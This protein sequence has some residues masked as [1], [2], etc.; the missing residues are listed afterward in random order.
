MMNPDMDTAYSPQW[1]VTLEHDIAGKGVIGSISYVGANGIKLYSLN[2]LNQRGSCLLAPDINPTCVPDGSRTSRLNQTGLTGMNRRGN[3][4]L[5][6]YNGMILSLR[7]PRLGNTGLSLS[8]SYGWSH[9]IDNE[10]SFFADSPFEANYGFGFRNGFT[11]AMDRASSTNDIRHRY[12]VGWDWQIPAARHMGGVGG[13]TLGGWSVS[14]VFAAQTG[15][16]FSVY[17]GSTDSQCNSDGTNFCYPLLVGSVPTMSATPVPDAPNSFALYNIGSTF[18]TQQAYCAGDLACTAELN[19]LH[20]DLLS[21]RNLFRTPGIYNWD[22]GLLKDFKLPR[23][24]MKVQFRA[25]FFN[26]LNHSNLYAYPGTNVYAGSDSTVVAKRGLPAGGG[27]ER[28]NIQ[29]ALR[30]V[31]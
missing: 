10:S 30:F 23:E 17:D 25:E 11:P 15:G 24:G 14:G 29:L 13:Q 12:S 2:N 1:N 19:I 7:A 27:A 6:R 3:E 4:G 5:S 22:L 26:I 16:A 8:T 21:P 28:R 31:W 18:Q 9:N 20:P